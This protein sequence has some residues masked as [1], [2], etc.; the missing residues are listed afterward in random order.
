VSAERS[1][2]TT[3]FV[4]RGQNLGEAD[5]I[6]TLFTASR[7]KLDAI[8]KGARRTKSHFAGRLEFMSEAT[9]TLHRGRNLDVITS[10]EI[11]H[12][13]WNMVVRPATFVAA[14]AMAEVVNA[15]CEPDL[16]QPEIY[17]LLSA[18]IWSFRKA[19]DIRP[20]LPRFYLRLLDALGLAPPS[21]ACV[22][23]GAEFMSNA[24][25]RVDLESGGL[26]CI[27]CLMAGRDVIELSPSDV[28]NFQRLGAP[29]S[30]AARASSTATA[31]SRR[32]IEAFLHYHLGKRPK[33]GLSA[34]EFVRP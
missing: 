2:K 28:E 34:E 32:A 20:L 3:A 9:L 26:A 13:C 4:L 29:K 11:V 7:G 27:G 10:A 18:A 19:E 30:G 23:C 16:A 1:Y 6:Y 12:S 33:A 14:H 22:R 24:S 5:K 17:A 25:A 8:A 21:G 31:T 15:F